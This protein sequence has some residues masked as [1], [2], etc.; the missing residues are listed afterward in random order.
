MNEIKLN[1]N[2]QIAVDWNEGPLLVLAGPGS[3]KTTVLT[4]RIIRIL[5]ETP[6]ERFKILALTF[7]KNAARNMRGRVDEVIIENR[8]RVNLTNF[9]SFCVDVIRQHG[10]LEGINTDFNILSIDEDR[11][12]LLIEVISDAIDLGLDFSMEDIKHLSVINSAL[13]NC[14]I[15]E[16]EPE[17]STNSKKLAYL[18]FNYVK[19]MKTTSRIDY[20]G[21]LYFAWL[22]LGKKQVFKHYS[23]VYKYICVDEYQ[24]TNLVQYNLLTKL[25]KTDNPNLFLVADDDQIIYQW[26]G[27]SPDRINEIVQ[28]YKMTVFQLP[29]NYRCP[30]EVVD[31]ANKMISFNNI[32]FPEKMAGISQMSDK[33]SKHIRL[34]H[35]SSFED[36]VTWIGN[37]IKQ[38]K[39]KSTEIK[40]MARTR[41]LLEDTQKI[42]EN[43]GVNSVIHQRKN[44]FES[45]PMR[46]FES[47]LKLF[48]LRTDRTQLQ[49][50]LASFY[51]ME[52]VNIDF[53]S[54]I[55]QSGTT[56]GDLFLA[57]VECIKEHKRIEERKKSII[58]SFNDDSFYVNYN[59]LIKLLLGFLD[60]YEDTEIAMSDDK[61]D[62]YFEEKELFNRIKTEIESESSE[63]S[64][65]GFLQELDLRDKSDPVPDDAIE[66]ITIHAAKGLEFENVY[67]LGMVDDFLPAYNSIKQDAKPESLEEERRSCYVAITRTL[68]KLTITYADQYGR[69]GKKPSRFLYEMGLLEG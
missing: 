15:V 61:L 63:L 43:L 29:E 52:G 55:V 13:E 69:W 10:A 39:I 7:T 62:V 23:I 56:N 49:R 25:L 32:R 31:I 12:E 54:I 17:P 65:S 1:K 26:N 47:L 67:L 11:K 22:L 8:D 30:Q 24:D 28:K 53:H 16:E 44:D 5:N 40:I 50:I 64:L 59:A 60:G 20:A 42:L 46:F 21:L 45:A 18:F 14:V 51:K 58:T 19:K 9:H 4:Q 66:L 27:A 68:E 35:F 36:E 38:Q 3:G 2:Q 41:K 37:D 33:G 34:E 57:F 6:E 48:S